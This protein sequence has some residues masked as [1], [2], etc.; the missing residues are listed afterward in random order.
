MIK[1]IKG[2]RWWQNRDLWPD[3][4]RHALLCSWLGHRYTIPKMSGTLCS[5]CRAFRPLS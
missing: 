3:H 4:I 1:G 5:R 2:T